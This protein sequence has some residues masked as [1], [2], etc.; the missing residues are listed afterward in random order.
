MIKLWQF[1]NTNG[2]YF[3]IG[4]IFIVVLIFFFRE[5]DLTS[6]RAWAML[7]S[8][9]ALGAVMLYKAVRKNRLLDELRKRKKELEKLEQEYN[10]LKER[11]EISEENYEKARKDLEAAKKKM[12][13]DLVKA[14][15]EHEQRLKEIEKDFENKS[16]DE[17]MDMTEELLSK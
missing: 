5:F 10:E 9:S 6:K 8:L 3:L 12:L 16:A 2:D 1:I 4:V 14:D 11:H 13:R 17:L 7:L 15:E